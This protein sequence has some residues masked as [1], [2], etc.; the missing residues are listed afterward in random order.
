[1]LVREGPFTHSTV[2]YRDYLDLRPQATAFDRLAIYGY[3]IVPI[4][5]A[6]ED[7]AR[8]RFGNFVS[9][10]F[11]DVIGLPMGLGRSFRPDE[12]PP[13]HPAHVVILSDEYWRGDLHADP[14]VLGRTL[15][16]AGTD[17]TIIGVAPAFFTGL[18]PFVREAIF[19]PIGLM[20]RL[21]ELHPAN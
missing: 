4:Q 13:E 18:H 8:M 20:P 5:T 19:L 17:L 2:S 21:A 12:V 15:R 11:F 6:A 1:T 9:D 16:V 14:S 3:G 10:T 7:A